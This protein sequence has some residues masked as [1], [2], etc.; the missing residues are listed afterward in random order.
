MTAKMFDQRQDLLELDL[1]MDLADVLRKRA[2]R[3]TK[4]VLLK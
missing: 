2:V 1:V 3:L 4:K